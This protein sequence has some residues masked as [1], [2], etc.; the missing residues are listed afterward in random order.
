M[1]RFRKKNFRN[2]EPFYTFW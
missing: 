1:I 2:F